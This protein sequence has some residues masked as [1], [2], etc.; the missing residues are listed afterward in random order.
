MR[1]EPRPTILLLDPDEL[2]PDRLGAAV[3]ARATIGG[4]RSLDD[5]LRSLD[6][7]AFDVVVVNLATADP[8][9][10][11]LVPAL[12]GAA[13]CTPVVVL[14]GPDSDDAG[15]RALRAGAQDHL[16]EGEGDADSILRVLRYAMERKRREQSLVRHARYDPLTDLPNRTLF[17]ET[18]DRA[19][20]RADR[21]GQTVAVLW[22]DLDG[23]RT[24]TKGWARERSDELLR[25]AGV[26][27]HRSVRQVDT[28]A[29]P[30]GDE[31]TI[32]L[33]GLSGP[34]DAEI[35]ARKIGAALTE[36]LLRDEVVRLSASIG[37]SW[38]PGGSN[39]RDDLLDHAQRG[40]RDAKAAGK[41]GFSF[42]PA[43]S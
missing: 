28:V 33:E 38:Y 19:L 20:A 4:A 27:L 11:D 7:S 36:P 22:V 37:I 29:H 13:P 9:G 23:F 17:R 10:P 6:E 5:A 26:R 24:A 21:T 39:D 16:V 31:F 2:G 12:V 30:A 35:V 8:D 25:M 40:L 32:L 15:L 34:R 1:D 14:T 18:L 3:G 42:H 41:G 43:P